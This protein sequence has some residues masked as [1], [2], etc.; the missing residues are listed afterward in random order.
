LNAAEDLAVAGA[1]IVRLAAGRGGARNLSTA[2]ANFIVNWEAEHYRAKQLGGT[3]APLAGKVALV[4]GAASGLGCGIAMG[5]VEAGAAV[6]FC[7]I[8]DPGAQEAVA[9]CADPRRA[10]AV[11]MDVTSEESTAAAF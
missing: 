6:A 8:D 3:Q 1:R 2:S 10:L 5:L 9:D 7:D 11:H 4:T